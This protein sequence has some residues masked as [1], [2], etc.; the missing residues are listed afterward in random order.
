[1]LEEF[2]NYLKLNGS[3]EKTIK[4]Y[5]ERMNNFFNSYS[6]FTEENIN[7]YLVNLVNL[8]KSSSTFN[9]TRSTFKKFCEFK[10]L[11]IK[12]PNSRKIARTLKTTLTRNE[13]ENEIFPYFDM[14]FRDSEKRKLIVRF[15]MLTMLRI[16]EVTNLKKADVDFENN[17]I[18]V[19]DGKGGKNRIVFLNKV[20]ADDLKKEYNKNNRESLFNVSNNYIRY[21]FHQI[22]TMINYKKVITPHTLRHA[23]AKYFFEHTKDLYALKELLGHSSIETTIRYLNYSTDEIQKIYNSVKYVK[24]VRE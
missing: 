11:D 2:E 24:G 13:I 5:L 6:D 21:I 7:K 4:N 15:M 18:K 10:K 8:K 1:M 20:I 23:G 19:Y 9:L 3:S 14:M 12:F 17:Q 16:S 22:N